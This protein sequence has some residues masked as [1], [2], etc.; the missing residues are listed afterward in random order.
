MFD[1]ADFIALA[2]GFSGLNLDA[3]GLHRFRKLALQFNL[4]QAI[5]ERGSLYDYVIGEIKPALE[6]SSCDAA[7]KVL[8]LIFLLLL[9]CG[10]GNDQRIL[11][12]GHID[13]FRLKTCNRSPVRTI[14]Q[15]G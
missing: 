3:T 10:C 6:R 4:K 5:I 11:I 15:G 2:Y 7:I 9:V 13:L 8:T 12:D 14:L 1:G